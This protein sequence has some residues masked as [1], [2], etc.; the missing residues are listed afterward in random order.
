MKTT[1]QKVRMFTLDYFDAA[2][3][4]KKALISEPVREEGL[5]N[6]GKFE[7]GGSRKK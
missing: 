4:Q 2:E 6:E 1:A 5:R 7:E 3:L